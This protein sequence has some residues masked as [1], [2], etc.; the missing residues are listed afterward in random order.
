MKYPEL[1]GICKTALEKNMCLGC[2]KL[3]DINF[4]GQ[5][6][7]EIVEEKKKKIYGVQ[8]RIEWKKN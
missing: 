8:E 3:E 5:P 2:S 4:R 6:K 1:T 7:C